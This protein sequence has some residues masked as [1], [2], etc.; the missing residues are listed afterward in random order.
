MR[1]SQG[2]QI[3]LG[4]TK[5]CEWRARQDSNPLPLPSEEANAAASDGTAACG[6]RFLVFVSGLPRGRA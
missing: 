4:D 2:S 3:E 6:W 1:F 5:R